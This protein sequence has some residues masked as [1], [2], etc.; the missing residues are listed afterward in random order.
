MAGAYN[1]ESKEIYDLLV[2]K[3]EGSYYNVLGFPEKIFEYL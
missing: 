1:I 3:I 2:K